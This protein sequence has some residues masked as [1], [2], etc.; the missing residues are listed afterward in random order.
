[1]IEDDAAVRQ[2]QID[3]EAATA[4]SRQTAL[5]ATQ[6]AEN[7]RNDTVMS[8]METDMTRAM[9][10][11][12]PARPAPAE[13]PKPPD[14]TKLVDRKDYEGLAFALLGM[15]MIG[16]VASRGNWLGVSSSLNGALKGYKAGN[17]QRA[18]T[19]L[20]DYD[21][22]FKTAKEAEVQANDQYQRILDDRKLTIN[23]KLERIKVE[24]AR[25][26]RQDIALAAEQRSIDRLTQQIDAGRNQ[27]LNTV[28]RHE[29]LRASLEVKKQLHALT[30]AA[31]AGAA[32]LTPEAEQFVEQVAAGGNMELVRLVSGRYTAKGAIPLLNDMAHQFAATGEDPRSLT[33]AKITVAAEQSAAR[34]ATIKRQGIERL[35]DS[36]QPLEQ[37]V[38]QLLAQL[39]ARG[40]PP[41]NATVNYLRQ[42]FGDGPLQELKTLM[43]SVGRQYVEAITM[44]GSNAQMHATAQDWAQGLINENISLDQLQGSLRGMNMEINSTRKALEKQAQQPQDDVRHAGP[45]I[46]PKS[47]PSGAIDFSQL[48]PG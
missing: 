40:I 48:P 3:A 19:M 30:A 26:G 42:T 24:A 32:Q 2:K 38:Q 37:R 17:E 29:D 13:L 8:A 46:A 20:A 31:G 35:T 41:A 33:A 34:Q 4:V 36:L 39:N 12:M 28:Q 23:E 15:A 10:Q 25:H 6:Q 11:S 27:L 18:T 5:D 16:G 47:A 43:S 21:R 45:T 22:Q 14:V 44:P 9:D 1:M 7:S